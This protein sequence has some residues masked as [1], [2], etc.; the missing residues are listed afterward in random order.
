M[1]KIEELWDF[2]DPATSEAKFRE[3]L[4]AY[5]TNST[6]HLELLTQIARSKF[7]TK[8]Y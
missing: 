2:S 5:K 4:T 1:L 3:C 7:A 8:L 6:E